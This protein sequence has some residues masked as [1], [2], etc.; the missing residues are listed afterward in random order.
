MWAGMLCYVYGG[1]NAHKI[2]IHLFLFDVFAKGILNLKRVVCERGCYVR[3][4]ACLRPLLWK[5]DTIMREEGDEEEG[6][7]TREGIR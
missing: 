1:E 2:V 3:G 6:N 7:I 4:G 5:D